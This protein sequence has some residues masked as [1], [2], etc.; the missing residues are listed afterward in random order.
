MPI[1]QVFEHVISSSEEDFFYI[2]ENIYHFISGLIKKKT[3]ENTFVEM[4][5]MRI[6]SAYKFFFSFFLELSF[7][8]DFF[9][10]FH[11]LL[12]WNQTFFGW[13]KL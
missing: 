8:D 11:L 7:S 10:L 1:K 5:E 6:L 2:F 3:G 12:I 4:K 13:K 9:F